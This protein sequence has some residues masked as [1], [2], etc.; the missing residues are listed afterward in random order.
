MSKIVVIDIG[1]G[2]NT[3]PP[4]KGVGN[5]AEHN[6]NSAVAIKAKELA[7]H[8]GFTVL[9]S[10]QPY[11]DEVPLN[12][13][14]AWINAQHRASPILC[15][16]SI[17]ANAGGNASGHDVFHWHKSKNGKRLAQIWNKY[18]K[19]KL[20]IPQHGQGIW[21][22]K[23]GNFNFHM[24]RETAPPAIIAEHFYYT[25]PEE[26]KKC[27]TPEFVNLAAEVAARTICEYAGVT[28]K[29]PAQSGGGGNPGV[30]Y[31]KLYEEAMAKLEQIKKIIG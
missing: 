2:A 8:N 27:N 21:E 4:S 28:Y 25:N 12:S 23:P 13:R 11:A 20:P 18:A 17:H 24:V 6:F 15:L 3:Y 7:E 26:L 19:E 9:F 10:Q 31:K 14:S 29:E 16:L 5:F 30:D 22:S 1:H